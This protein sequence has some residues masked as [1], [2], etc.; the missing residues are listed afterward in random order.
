MLASALD[1]LKK[2]PT[3]VQ[4][5]YKNP[6]SIGFLFPSPRM[7]NAA[8]LLWHPAAVSVC[9]QLPLG[10]QAPWSTAGHDFTAPDVRGPESPVEACSSPWHILWPRRWAQLCGAILVWGSQC[11]LLPVFQK[12]FTSLFQAQAPKWLLKFPIWCVCYIF[13]NHPSICLRGTFLNFKKK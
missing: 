3:L 8:H 2:T 6:S 13:V 5:S 1:M 12:L 10:L 7:E 9:P 4:V 11:L